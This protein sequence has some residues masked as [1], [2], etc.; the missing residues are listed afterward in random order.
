LL[1]GVVVPVV[2]ALGTNTPIYE[3]LFHAL[4]PFRFPRVPERLMPITC[5]CLAALVGFALGRRTW[6]AVLAVAVLLVDLHVQVYRESAPGSPERVAYHGDGRVLELPIFDPSVHFGSVYLWYD[7]ASQRERPSGYSTT[8]PR[9]AKRTSDRLQRLN[10][11]DW[12]DDTAALLDDLGVRA[13]ALHIGLYRDNAAWFAWQS[14]LAHGWTVQRTA[15]PVWLFERKPIGLPPTLPAPNPTTPVFCQGWY[16]KV[17]NGRYMSETHAPFWVYGNVGTLKIDPASP[18][19]RVRVHPGP[20]KWTLVTFD[21][22]HLVRVPGQK[23][24]VG[25]RLVR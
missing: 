23:R 16:G 20:G 10:C 1:V 12:S 2:L 22:P 11:G 17:G 18:E 7:T 4:P 8:A 21:V 9:A 24:L 13:I 5:L 3:P 6:V 14:L 25:A 19:P 15:G